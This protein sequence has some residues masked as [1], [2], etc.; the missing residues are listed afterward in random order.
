M[1]MVLQYCN[2]L[3]SRSPPRPKVAAEEHPLGGLLRQFHSQSRR[4]SR[5][6][7]AAYVAVLALLSFAHHCDASHGPHADLP[8]GCH[9]FTTDDGDASEPERPCTICSWQKT[10]AAVALAAPARVV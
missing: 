7:L 4:H 5:F 6:V 10:T 8:H 3:F 9:F 1:I 2:S